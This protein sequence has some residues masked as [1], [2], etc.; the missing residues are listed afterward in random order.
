MYKS[1]LPLLTIL[2]LVNGCSS[3][4]GKKTMNTSS[5]IILTSNAFKEGASIP[6]QFT[7]EGANISPELSW[8]GIPKQTKSVALIVDDPDAPHGTWV[9]WVVFNIPAN[10]T[11]LPQKASINSI[12][13]IEGLTS[14]NRI[15]YSGPCPPSGTHR[16]YFKLYALDSLLTLDSTARK[17]K[18]IEAMQGHILAEGQLMGRYQKTGK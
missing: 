13:G 10:V 2:L 9:H 5:H 4:N 12:G 3:D 8:S 16:Y 15:G 17:E 7:C 14:Y 11:R 6:A 18:V 1:Y